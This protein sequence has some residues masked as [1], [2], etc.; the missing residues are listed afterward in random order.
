MTPEQKEAKAQKKD[1]RERLIK[2]MMLVGKG[3]NLTRFI[4]DTMTD[5]QL[6]RLAN[7]IVKDFK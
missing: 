3:S 5:Q 7:R 6:V 2:A 1:R 4:L